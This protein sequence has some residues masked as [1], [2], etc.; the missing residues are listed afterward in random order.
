MNVRLDRTSTELLDKLAH[1]NHRPKTEIVSMAI[2]RYWRRWLLEEN[3]RAYA[4]LAADPEKWCQELEE[5]KL[6][7]NTL[8][9][10]L[11]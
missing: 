1:L 6:W 5:R 3:N 10:G 9:D 7:D 8:A 4:E 11:E 2:E